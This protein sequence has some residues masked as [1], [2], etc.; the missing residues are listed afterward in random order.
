MKSA[1]AITTDKKRIDFTTGSP[2]KLILAFYWPLLLTSMLQQFYNFAD[3]W[4]VGK[5][6]GDN[7]LAA[8]GNMGSLFF[9]IVG[10]SFGLANG[11]SVLV[12]QSFGAKD[13]DTM[14]N[15]LAGVIELGIILAVFLSTVSVVFLPHALRLL[16]TDS[17]IMQ[18]SLIYGYIIFGGISTNIAYN[19]SSAVLRALGDSKTPLKAII[20]SSI[21]NIG[22]NSLFI[23]V[24]HMGV[25]GAAIATIIAQI[26]SAFICINR[27]RHIEIIKLEKSNFQLGF[28]A[29][30][31]LLKNGLPM[32]F[33]NSITAIGCMVVQY[34]VNGAGV[35][36]TAAYAACSK[37]L[38]LFMNP[39][40]TAG[41]AMSAYTSQNY[42][43]KEYKRI[44]DGL[45]VCL[46]IAAT[47]YVILGSL[48]IFIPAK[49]AAILLSGT[50]QIRL[51]CE[52]LPRC[53]LM[54]I[55][56]DTLFVV[57]S[58]VQ[59]MGKPMLPMVSGILEMFLRIFTISF[60]I[61][62]IGFP[63][64]AYAE[65]SAWIGALIVNAFAFYISL[66]PLLYKRPAIRS[67][68]VYQ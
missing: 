58:A 63:A 19:I 22:L 3:T 17:L 5:G 14:R 38:N 34:F 61:G 18:D 55:F 28:K 67:K 6:L 36:Y 44:R 21:L 7:A 16:R 47:S 1:S 13:Y 46:G 49:L 20:T 40:S 56:V 41:N 24:F 51:V 52:F 43:A 42:G 33:M 59:G 66:V 37:Y 8:V 57:R 48:M 11:F 31:E 10:F 25:E 54:M 50:E 60:F 64:T 35:V 12:A 27:L 53:G 30:A 65:I 26:I 68:R 32:A 62:R 29:F 2:L 9:L 45:F 4:I 39:A 23:F 15:R